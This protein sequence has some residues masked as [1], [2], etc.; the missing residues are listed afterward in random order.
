[1]RSVAAVHKV[2]LAGERLVLCHCGI[3]LFIKKT[4]IICRKKYS[5]L[6]SYLPVEYVLE[7]H[8]IAPQGLNNTLAFIIKC[9]QLNKMHNKSNKY[10]ICW[11]SAVVRCLTL[12]QIEYENSKGAI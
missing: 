1:M 11:S 9:G 4:N 2:R 7:L 12:F 5:S 10:G 3:Y 6:V 8:C